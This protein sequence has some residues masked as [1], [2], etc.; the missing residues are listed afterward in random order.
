MYLGRVSVW[1]PALQGTRHYLLALAECGSWSQPNSTYLMLR[2]NGAS[3]LTWDA[4]HFGRCWHADTAL[5][6]VQSTQ[7]VGTS[8]M[9]H[10][11]L[12]TAIRPSEGEAWSSVLIL[13][14]P[15]ET[16]NCTPRLHHFLQQQKNKQDETRQDI[17]DTQAL[18]SLI[19]DSSPNQ[20]SLDNGNK[21]DTQPSS[22]RASASTTASLSIF[23]RSLLLL[24][25]SS[26]S[27]LHTATAQTFL[28]A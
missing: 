23:P 24:L 15:P 12:G 18:Y 2:Y 8:D 21:Q 5:H 3:H 20:T 10:P 27:C 7:G 4:R 13:C 17:L 16:I 9:A 14:S 28:L 6:G 19:P 22:G 25:L 1:L 11:V 26:L